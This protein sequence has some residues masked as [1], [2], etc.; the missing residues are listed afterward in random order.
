MKKFNQDAKVSIS[1]IILDEKK[2]SHGIT[3]NFITNL[4]EQDRILKKLNIPDMNINVINMISLRKK[5]EK[6]KKK[7]YEEKRK[8][9]LNKNSEGKYQNLRN[10][11][12]TYNDLSNLKKGTSQENLEAN[13]TSVFK[14]E[15]V[16]PDDIHKKQ[17]E[18]K[19][20]ILTT[21]D[22]LRKDLNN[23]ILSEMILEKM[24]ELEK[25]NSDG[26]KLKDLPFEILITHARNAQ[27]KVVSE[28][29]TF[30]NLVIK[31]KSINLK[32]IV[33]KIR[34]GSHDKQSKK[35]KSQEELTK[36]L[37]Q[38]KKKI[39]LSTDYFELENYLLEKYERTFDEVKNLKQKLDKYIINDINVVN[40]IKKLRVEV[41]KFY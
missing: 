20:G 23:E 12:K 8:K 9:N 10:F 26:K 36:N 33:D 14:N 11:W 2:L 38:Q 5:F 27:K 34:F 25:K 37:L 24:K 7:F 6:E 3:A 13:E 35:L 31:Q 18:I 39:D 32:K 21:G 1:I 41:I 40:Q 30:Q 16:N 29:K 19:Q 4:E 17:V 15:D 28:F 22:S